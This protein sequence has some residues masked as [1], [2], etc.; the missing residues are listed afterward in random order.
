MRSGEQNMSTTK[1]MK[2]ATI[3][4]MF[5]LTLGLMAIAQGVGLGQRQITTF[6]GSAGPNNVNAVSAGIGRVLGVAAGNGNVY[7]SAGANVY[8]VDASGN[9]TLV[10]GNGS[11]SF[12]GDGGPAS[13][14][15]VSN[16]FGLAPDSNGNLFIADDSNARIRRVD[17][18]TG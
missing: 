10:A 6:A 4:V 14:A 3:M 2:H 11:F 12:S 5:I 16:P 15:A 7:I 13:T 1:R 9:L 17:A 8:K 18:K